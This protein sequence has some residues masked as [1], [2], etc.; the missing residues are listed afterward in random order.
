MSVWQQVVIVFSATEGAFDNVPVEN[1]RAAQDAMLGD[2]EQH[3]KAVI[4]ELAKGDKPTDAAKKAI[5]SSAE[6]IAKQYRKVETKAEVI[7]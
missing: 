7:S 6:K 1:L 5:I 3:H 2:I 4:T